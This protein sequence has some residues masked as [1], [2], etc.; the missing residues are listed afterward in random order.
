VQVDDLQRIFSEVTKRD[1]SNTTVA[2]QVPIHACY[3]IDSASQP[4]ILKGTRASLKHGRFLMNSS[5]RCVNTADYSAYVPYSE[6]IPREAQG[7]SFTLNRFCKCILLDKW[8]TV[9]QVAQPVM[10]HEKCMSSVTYLPKKI[11]KL[12]DAFEGSLSG[13]HELSGRGLVPFSAENKLTALGDADA[14]RKQGLKRLE[15]PDSTSCVLKVSAF[16]LIKAVDKEWRFAVG[17]MT[18]LSAVLG[19]SHELHYCDGSSIG[20]YTRKKR[21]P[22]LLSAE[23][24]RPN[25]HYRYAV[26]LSQV[27]CTLASTKDG[28]L[29]VPVMKTSY[30][31]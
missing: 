15:C 29:F 14:L 5:N 17:E 3:E 23:N 28:K 13:S 19:A 20:E 1:A 6:E 22:S 16:Y 18:E 27:E 9:L 31:G 12:P 11:P 10:K 26:W 25:Q 8:G 24:A 7:K 4:T 2:A 30:L 21:L